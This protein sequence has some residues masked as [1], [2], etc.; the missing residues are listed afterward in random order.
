MANGTMADCIFLQSIFNESE[1]VCSLIKR[2]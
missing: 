2:F 1:K